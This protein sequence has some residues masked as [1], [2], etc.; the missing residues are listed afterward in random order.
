MNNQPR[1]T[2]HSNKDDQAKN[3]MLDNVLAVETK[4]KHAV[5]CF[6]A[7][8]SL[9]DRSRFLNTAKRLLALN[10]NALPDNSAAFT[11]IGLQKSVK[12]RNEIEKLKIVIAQIK[13]VAPDICDM[14]IRKQRSTTVIFAEK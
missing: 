6:I 9:A 11:P 1:E 13:R 12:Q 4:D 7:G 2:A 3:D 8:N 5:D 10:T 14:C